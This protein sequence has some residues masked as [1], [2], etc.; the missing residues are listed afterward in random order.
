M[1]VYKYNGTKV[2]IIN[3]TVPSCEFSNTINETHSFTGS[4]STQFTAKVTVYI[5]NIEENIKLDICINNIII[6]N[7]TISHWMQGSN[8]Y[9]G[10]VLLTDDQIIVVQSSED[11]SQSDF[12]SVRL[13]Y[14][15][16]YLGD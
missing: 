8:V 13:D 9:L 10:A 4:Y 15:K 5:G 14:E 11:L 6:G 7:L 1:K 3:S 12:L 2:A 16:T